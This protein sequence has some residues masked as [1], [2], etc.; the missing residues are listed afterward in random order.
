LTEK[1]DVNLNGE[2]LGQVLFKSL[3][4]IT[5]YLF[6]YPEK[7]EGTTFSF[8]AIL[9]TPFEVKTDDTATIN[10]TNINSTDSVNTEVYG[11]KELG[12]NVFHKLGYISQNVNGQENFV[13]NNITHL[14]INPTTPANVDKIQ[15][16]NVNTNE[17]ICSAKYSNLNRLSDNIFRV[18][19]TESGLF[20]YLGDDPVNVI[21]TI[22]TLST[23]T[24]IEMDYIAMDLSNIITPSTP[25]TKPTPT[26]QPVE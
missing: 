13:F 7:T 3:H 11:I 1:I 18:E 8:N 10:I 24:Q 2:P 12:S 16:K 14:F 25:P 22:S 19:S 4:K 9:S 17:L 5:N 21:L 23:G 15:I 26:P 6:G 20:L